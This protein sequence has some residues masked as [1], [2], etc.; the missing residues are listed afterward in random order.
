[1]TLLVHM[2]GYLTMG[3]NYIALVAKDVEHLFTGIRTLLNV[4]ISSEV[5]YKF[6]S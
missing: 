2:K 5:K 6:F 3:L 1:M 4:Y